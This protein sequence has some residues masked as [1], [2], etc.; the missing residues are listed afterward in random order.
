MLFFFCARLSS[1]TRLRLPACF[2]SFYF[3][4]YFADTSRLGKT[5]HPLL[6][7]FHGFRCFLIFLPS[8]ISG[9]RRRR[10]LFFFSSFSLPRRIACTCKY[11]HRHR[12]QYTSFVVLLLTKQSKD[13]YRW[14]KEQEEVHTWLLALGEP[15]QLCTHRYS[16]V[17]ALLDSSP[18]EGME[19][20]ILSQIRS[21]ECREN[22]SD[23]WVGRLG[24][25]ID[26]AWC[27]STIQ[28]PSNSSPRTQSS[29]VSFFS[30][31]MVPVRVS[32]CLHNF[33]LADYLPQLSL[34]MPLPIRWPDTIFAHMS[35]FNPW[36]AER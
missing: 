23:Q 11:V 7:M 21:T 32:L 34:G 22:P 30:E 8:D 36:S 2:P 13:N 17:H 14:G 26:I 4:L 29:T 33:I 31:L 3:L 16:A 15:G 18:K 10:A 19:G 24:L 12:M 20:R 1:R 5:F 35:M 9:R 27:I 28:S 25:L 6:Q